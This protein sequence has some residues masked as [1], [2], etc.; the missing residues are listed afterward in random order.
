MVDRNSL[1]GQMAVGIGALVAVTAAYLL[2]PAGNRQLF[3][4]MVAGGFIGAGLDAIV[5]GRLSLAGRYGPAKQWHGAAARIG[6][7]VLL[8]A[9]G[10][11][12]YAVV[13]LSG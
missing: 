5:R 3:L 13:A 1:I 2:R 9:S 4:A 7:V 6:G 11:L 10:L 8:F 12:F